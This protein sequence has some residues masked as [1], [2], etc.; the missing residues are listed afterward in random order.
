MKPVRGQLLHLRTPPGTM[1]HV[2]WGHDVYLVPWSDGTIYVGSDDHRLYAV[3]ADGRVQ[4]SL[5]TGSFLAYSSP[6]VDASGTVYVGSEDGKLYAVRPDGSPKWTFATG[7]A[8]CAL[9]GA[10]DWAYSGAV[11]SR[12]AVAISR[13]FIGDLLL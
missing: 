13:R 9:V 1:R 8:I 6:A 12:N 2:L 3:G 5:P 7:G 10:D 11:T 4:W